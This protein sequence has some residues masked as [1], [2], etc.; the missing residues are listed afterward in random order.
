MPRRKP[1]FSRRERQIMDIVYNLREATAAEVHERLPDAPTYTAVR[2]LLRVLLDKGHL[3]AERDGT[4]LVYRPTRP[5][6]T[7]GASMLQHVIRTFFDGSPAKA[8]AALVGSADLRL[9]DREL[10]RLSAIVAEA[11][12]EEPEP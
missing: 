12:E 2:G 4:H 9:D 11:R 6:E 3:R 8:M 5:R 7:E 1:G 10:A